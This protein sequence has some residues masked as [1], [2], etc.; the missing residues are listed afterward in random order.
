M[1]KSI[2]ITALVSAIIT[3]FFMYLDSRLFDTPKSRFAYVKGITFVSGL[4]T[5]IVYFMSPSTGPRL[6]PTAPAP[7]PNPNFGGHNS[8]GVVDGINEE[9]LTGFPTF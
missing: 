1:N 7:G 9:I 8:T 6:G 3:W 2:I 4:S 5:A